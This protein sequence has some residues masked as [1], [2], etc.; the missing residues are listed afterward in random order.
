MKRQKTKIRNAFGN[1]MLMDVKF[2]KSQLSKI[3]KS[4]GFLGETLRNMIRDLGE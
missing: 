4:G 3:M 2:S 1:N